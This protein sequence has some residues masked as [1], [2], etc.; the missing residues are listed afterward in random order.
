MQSTKCIFSCFA[1]A[2]T[3]FVHSA[4]HSTS[5]LYSAFLV[6]LIWFHAHITSAITYRELVWLCVELLRVLS[7]SSCIPCIIINSLKM[8]SRR[9]YW[10]AAVSF[11]LYILFTSCAQFLYLQHTYLHS[12]LFQY[13]LLI[14]MFNIFNTITTH[15]KPLQFISVAKYCTFLILQIINYQLPLQFTNYKTTYYY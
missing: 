13:L 6:V 1:S 10:C 9:I 15:N 3:A 2:L 4:K 12:P 8:V 11:F 5:A 7:F 14:N